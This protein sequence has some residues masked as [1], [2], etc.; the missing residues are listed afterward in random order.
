M[1]FY[2]LLIQMLR[3][4]GLPLGQKKSGKTKKKWQKSGKNGW[5]Q[6]KS[7]GTWQNS[8]KCQILPVQIY[9]TSFFSKAFK[10]LEINKNLLKSD[11]IAKF[12]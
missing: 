8:K 4:S 7:Q 1:F 11:W 3:N 5:F 9:K 12:S 6:K 2:S 10:R